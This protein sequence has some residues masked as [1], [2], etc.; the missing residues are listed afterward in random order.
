M[1]SVSAGVEEGRVDFAESGPCAGISDILEAS[2]IVSSTAAAEGASAE[3]IV[4]RGSKLTGAEAR[5]DFKSS[6][7]PCGKRRKQRQ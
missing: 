3:A 7:V 5:E 4:A 1:L 2:L 6:G